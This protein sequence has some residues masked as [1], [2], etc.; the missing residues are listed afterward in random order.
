MIQFTAEQIAAV[1]NGT[2]YGDRN[3]KVWDVAPI[4]T[5]HNGQ[6]SYICDPKYLPLLHSTQA[7]VVLVS[8]S[9]ITP[10]LNLA[11]PSPTVIA[12]NNAREAMAVLLQEVSKVLNPPKK[13]VE[14]G[15]YISD[16]VQVPEDAYIG[17]G[18][19]IGKGVRLGAGVQIYP[20]VYIGDG[21][22]I[23]DKTTL[24]AGV[25]I[26]YGC[27]IGSQC[28]I[29]SGAVIGADGFGFE[30]DEDCIYHKIPQI[31][32]VVIEDDVE[33]GANTTIDRAMM[34]ETRIGR[35]TKIDNLCQIGH[36]VTIGQ[37]TILC[38]QVGI[39]GSTKVGSQCMLTGQVGVAG[40]LEIT[41][42]CII[43]AQSGVTKSLTKSGQYLGSPAMDADRSRRAM[44][45]YRNLP[46]LYK[47]IK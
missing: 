45:V 1:L 19:Y 43:G 31:G 7:S 30:P 23:G 26:Y 37:S 47:K 24:Y 36:N 34:G 33:I 14:K 11:Q 20:Q 5:A 27:V 35:N 41:D 39:A 38:G 25:K 29:H 3:N 15:A 28:I 16:D 18:A 10:D 17:A 21:S 44:A 6:L 32:R 12:V 8:Q 22:Q 2:I 42:G 9:L 46:E 4:E 13:G 40:H